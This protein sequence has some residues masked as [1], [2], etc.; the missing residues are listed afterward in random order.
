EA[1]PEPVGTAGDPEVMVVDGRPEYHQT[2]CSRLAGLEAEPIPLS[3]AR[4]DGFTPCPVCA[5][6]GSATDDPAVWVVDGNPE[7]HAETCSTV[8]GLEAEPIP[9]SQALEDG[10]VRCTVCTPPTGAAGLG[11]GGPTPSAAR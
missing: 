1:E 6:E 4:E 3:Q 2:G 7:Y 8:A 10:F 9:L 5:P 11:L